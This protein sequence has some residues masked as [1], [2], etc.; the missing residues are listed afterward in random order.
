VTDSNNLRISAPYQQ[1][2]GKPCSVYCPFRH[3][4]PCKYQGGAEVQGM[5]DLQKE[6]NDE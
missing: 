1:E 2:R 4:L 6:E 5:F 3:C